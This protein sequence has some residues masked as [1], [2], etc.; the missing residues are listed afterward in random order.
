[1]DSPVPVK[2]FRGSYTHSLDSKK[3]VVVPAKWREGVESEIFA[4]LATDGDHLILMTET[5]YDRMLETAKEDKDE[6]DP[7]VIRTLD[8]IADRTKTVTFDSQG[9]MTI[10]NDHF[11]ALNL[12]D[13]VRLVGRDFRFTVWK[14]ET[15][16]AKY[17]KE[18][19]DQDVTAAMKALGI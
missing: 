16:D 5:E 3:R 15:F 7:L 19:D 14:P 12:E 1:M 10:H 8:Q 9:R 13:T 4:L 6:Y 11:H 2:K 17:R 18:A